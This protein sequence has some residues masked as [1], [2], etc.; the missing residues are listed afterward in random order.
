[1]RHLLPF[2]AALGVVLLASAL[3][4]GVRSTGMSVGN[5]SILYLPAVLLAAVRFGR[6]P[7]IVA[8][9]GAFAL[10]DVLFVEPR[11]Q[12]DVA[13]PQEW[14][15]LLLLLLAAVVTGQVAA[16]QRVR[17]SEAERQEREAILL[18]DVT[19]L[20][21]GPDLDRAL[22]DVA[23]R[24][25]RELAFAGV[26]IELSDGA[27][28]RVATGDESAQQLL[29][30]VDV[31][32]TV[33]PGRAPTGEERGGPVRVVRVVPPY[34]GRAAS[35]ALSSVPILAQGRRV[36]ALLALAAGS[37]QTSS[38]EDRVL[39]AVAAQVGTAIERD[40]LRREAA[41]AEVLRRADEA[42]DVLLNAVSHDLRTP[43]A[44]VLA[45]ASNLRQR[46]VQWSDEERDQFLAAIEVE[47]RRLD[48]IVGELLDLSRVEAGALRPRRDWYDVGTLVEDV[49]GRLGS[50]IGDHPIAVRVPDDLPPASLDHVQIDQVLS[51]LIE[52]AANY[53]PDGSGIEVA[54][55]PQNGAIRFEVR[56]H[57][58]G[59]PVAERDRIF[60]PFERRARADGRGVGLGL[61]VARAF[62]EAH[63]GR[64]WVEGPEDGGSRFVFEVPGRPAV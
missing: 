15:A 36:G 44:S 53:S 2:A 30:S 63:G 56:D 8:S 10:Y 64:I 5:V 31:A 6:G 61:A 50:A 35:E 29:R 11:F 60:R 14:I 22:H 46:D 33:S 54:V 43:L 17:A 40:A 59:V 27:V 62:V 39:A 18:Y 57:G 24:A 3:I 19:R 1:M 12:I 42:K 28:R 41:E 21:A 34:A 23:E 7:A 45:A 37:R 52:N 55:R 16:D 48:R 25:R 32:R 47:T 58:P 51:N 38:D 20:M 26:A 49:V 4:A 9:I 13:D